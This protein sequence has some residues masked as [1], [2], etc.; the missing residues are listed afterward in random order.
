MAVPGKTCSA[1]IRHQACKS[2]DMV[3]LED[4]FQRGFI[5]YHMRYV[6]RSFQISFLFFACVHLII[7]ISMTTATT[8]LILFV[9][10]LNV[11]HEGALHV[12]TTFKQIFKHILMTLFLLTLRSVF[13]FVRF[14][15]ELPW[16]HCC[17]VLHY[18]LTKFNFLRCSRYFLSSSVLTILLLA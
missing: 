3:F 12:L 18:F 14:L 17:S 16:Y 4:Y 8:L 13:I 7:K 2:R 6:Y 5:Q 1:Q 9:N 15:T 11:S 10:I